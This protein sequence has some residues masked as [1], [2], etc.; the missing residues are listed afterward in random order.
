MRFAEM[1]IDYCK[2]VY[3]KGHSKQKQLIGACFYRISIIRV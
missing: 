2:Y 1:N 3:Q